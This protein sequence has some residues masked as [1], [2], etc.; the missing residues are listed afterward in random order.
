MK[1]EGRLHIRVTG[2]E[3]RMVRELA[4]DLGVT[5]TEAVIDSVRFAYLHLDLV[6]AWNMTYKDSGKEKLFIDIGA[7]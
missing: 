5:M 4:S 6:V 1:R 7:I 3:K 2:K